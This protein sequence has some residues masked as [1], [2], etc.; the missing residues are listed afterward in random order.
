VTKKPNLP[1]EE[2]QIS[3]KGAANRL[4]VALMTID[5]AIASG[6][7]RKHVLENGYNVVLDIREVDV[8]PVW[9]LTVGPR[10]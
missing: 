2:Y 3:K 9:R 4:G 1:P 7:L 10:V 5:R 8:L 6:K